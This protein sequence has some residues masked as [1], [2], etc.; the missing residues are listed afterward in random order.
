MRIG[1]MATGQIDW[2]MRFRLYRC[3]SWVLLFIMDTLGLVFS[4]LTV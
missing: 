3:R 1:V 4:P 2:G